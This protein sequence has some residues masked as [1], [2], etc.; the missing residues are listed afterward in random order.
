MHEAE[1]EPRRP[2]DRDQEDPWLQQR[3]PAASAGF[4]ER[5]LARVMADRARI[6]AEAEKVDQFQ[7]DPAFLA[8]L[9]PPQ[10]PADFVDRTLARVLAQRRHAESKDRALERLVQEYRVPP[11]SE[12]FVHRT[13]SALGSAG[14]RRASTAVRR[15]SLR[16]AVAAAAL[17]LAAPLLVG[18]LFMRPHPAAVE[19]PT[20]AAAYTPVRFGP[21]LATG[22]RL[23]GQRAAD[24]LVTLAYL[25]RQN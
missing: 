5:T 4:V 22:A 23:R 24:G 12:H 8:N 2:D 13:L 3:Y 25:A 14:W 6:D 16:W 18:P 15:P 10:V 7:F 1:H 19:R 11:V 21:V 20:A 17:L 9:E